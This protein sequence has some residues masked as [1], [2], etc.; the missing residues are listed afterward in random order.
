[1]TLVLLLKLQSSTSLD[2]F[3]VSI[4][5]ITN[6]PIHPVRFDVSKLSHHLDLLIYIS[7][8]S[9]NYLLNLTAL[10]FHRIVVIVIVVAV[11]FY[12]IILLFN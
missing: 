8:S 4:E 5:Q 7:F 12:F 3:M 11:V 10:H 9:I 1:M 6:D 2:V